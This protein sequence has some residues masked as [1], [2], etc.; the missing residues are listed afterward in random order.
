MHS[1]LFLCTVMHCFGSSKREPRPAYSCRGDPASR[2]LGAATQGPSRAQALCWPLCSLQVQLLHAVGE[3]AA[4]RGTVRLHPGPHRERH[5]APT[6]RRGTQPRL[7]PSHLLW[8]AGSG[9]DLPAGCRQR[10]AGGG[11]VAFRGLERSARQQQPSCGEPPATCNPVNLDAGVGRLSCRFAPPDGPGPAS[12]RARE[13]LGEQANHRSLQSTR[14]R[15]H[16]WRRTGGGFVPGPAAS[17]RSSLGCTRRWDFPCCP[18]L[19]AAET[20]ET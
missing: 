18:P 5:A 7:R 6:A 1:F 9:G 2:I 10:P 14:A 15:T 13:R 12:G 11:T 19:H 17:G 20:S 4:V 8:A 3:G 16:R